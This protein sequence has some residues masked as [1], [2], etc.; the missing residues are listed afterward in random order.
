MN[1]LKDLHNFSY[2]EKSYEIKYFFGGDWVVTA[3]LLGLKCANSKSPCLYCTKRKKEFG[4]LD[5]KFQRRDLK[6][7]KECLSKI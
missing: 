5:A 1:I 6:F 4:K 3:N 7:Q 2:K